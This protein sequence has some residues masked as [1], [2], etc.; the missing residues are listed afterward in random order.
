[1]EK[2][3]V[4]ISGLS[5]SG[6]SNLVEFISEKM[7]LKCIHTSSVLKELMQEKEIDLKNNF[8]KKNTGWWESDKA[9]EAFDKRLK[10]K[11]FDELL[12]KKL[13][14]LI[15]EGNVVM[16]SWTMGYLSKK[17]FKIWLSASAETRAKRIA[18]RNNQDF[19]KVLEAI[20]LKEEKTKEIYRK[21]YG[22]E[23]GEK[24]DKFNLVIKT[25]KIPEEEV[26]K[27]V[28]AEIKKHFS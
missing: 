19:E 24:L 26:R 7:N 2:K 17:G 21:L 3:V 9:K 6:K 14:E 28:L 12:D 8:G 27:I 11:K 5:G 1:M 10:E 22:F 13:L 25:E 15:E 18:K 16:D 20:K 4:I 23:L